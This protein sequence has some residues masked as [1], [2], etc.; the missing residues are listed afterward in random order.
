[1]RVKIRPIWGNHSL[2][3]YPPL[4]Y[5]GIR[6]TPLSKEKKKPLFKSS[7]VKRAKIIEEAYYKRK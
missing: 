3:L 4:V 7:S 1:M 2:T 6:G 5:D